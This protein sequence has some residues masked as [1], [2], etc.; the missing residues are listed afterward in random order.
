MT[1]Y[2]ICIERYWRIVQKCLVEFHALDIKEAENLCQ[3]AWRRIEAVST[4]GLPIFYHREAFDA[5]C[6]ISG[7]DIDINS[8]RDKYN[9]ICDEE[10]NG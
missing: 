2:K 4:S 6:L 7:K 1:K 3:D 10:L 8:L 5:A 9:Q